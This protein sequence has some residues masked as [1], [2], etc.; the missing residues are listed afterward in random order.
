MWQDPAQRNQEAIGLVL[1]V[2]FVHNDTSYDADIDS[3][4]TS[5]QHVDG[6]LTVSYIVLEVMKPRWRAQEN[7]LGARELSVVGAGHQEAVHFVEQSQQARWVVHQTQ[8]GEK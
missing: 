8:V 7:V 4:I 5:T 1:D 2:Y 3:P 6:Q